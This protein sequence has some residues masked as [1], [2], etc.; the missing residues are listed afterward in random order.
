MQ[1]FCILCNGYNRPKIDW[2]QLR[3]RNSARGKIRENL[4]KPNYIRS[5]YLIMMQKFCILCNGYN[6]PKID[7]IQLRCRNSERDKIRENLR[8]LEW[9]L[10]PGGSGGGEY[11]SE[12]SEGVCH[13]VLQ[14]MSLFPRTKKC[15]FLHPFSDLVC[16]IHTR[17]QTWLV[18]VV[19]AIAAYLSFASVLKSRIGKIHP[20]IQ[21]EWIFLFLYYSMK[22]KRKISFYAL[23]V[24]FPFSDQNG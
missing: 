17:F 8:K 24:P 13:P 10:Y 7:W 1:N 4:L 6:R 18:K 2:I 14:I 3:C 20:K 15:H 22:L 21:L 19:F 11:S 9:L 5:D 23:V 12:F 16:T